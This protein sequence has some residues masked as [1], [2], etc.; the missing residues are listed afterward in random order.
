MARLRADGYRVV[1]VARSRPDDL[2]N[3]EEFHTCDLTSF[4]ET[5][6]LLDRLLADGP[7]FGLVNNAGVAPQASLDETSFDDMQVAN[8]INVVVPL[9]LTQK[10]VP[11]MRSLGAGRVVNISSRAATGRP[12][13]TAYAAAKA[14]LE[15]MTRVWATELAA[16]GITV[17]A[18]A[19]GPIETELL[20]SLSGDDDS[21]MRSRGAA[22]PVGR[23]GQP[24]EIAHAVAF[25]MH[26]DAAFITGQV[27]RV[28]G[29]LT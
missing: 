15:G 24:R 18:I 3:D 9:L 19:P 14:G 7:F 20:R 1:G 5:V 16:A 21:A 26:D 25:L 11:G 29:G 17:N 28:D 2:G 4:D 22:V 27:I 13:R 6:N 10:V 8:V 23:I 12:N